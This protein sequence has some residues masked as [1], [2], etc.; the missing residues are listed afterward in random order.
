MLTVR[1]GEAGL[2]AHPLAGHGQARED[3]AQ[4]AAV[5]LARIGQQHALRHAPE[6]RHPQPVLELLHLL[7][8]GPRA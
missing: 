3:L 7:A 6:Q 8:D 2:A 5:E 4:F 1:I